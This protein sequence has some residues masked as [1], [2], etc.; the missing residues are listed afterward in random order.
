MKRPRRDSPGL[1]ILVPLLAFALAAILTGCGG[2]GSSAAEAPPLTKSDLIAKADVI[3]SRTDV[4]QKEQLVAYE[5][6]HPHTILAGKPGEQALSEAAFPPIRSEINQIVSL[7]PP[8]RHRR[9]L[10]TILDGW[11][12]ALEEVER[13]PGLVMGL[14]E[15]PFV[16]PDKLAAAYGF[17]SCAK[18]L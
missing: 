6:K 18:A 16:R 14:S 17:V 10:E 8:R 13:K 11:K 15:G 9:E 2:G 7:G 5:K 3:C 1:G 12:A 4:I